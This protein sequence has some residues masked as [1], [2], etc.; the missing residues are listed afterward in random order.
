MARL[1]F[2]EDLFDNLSRVIQFLV[3]EQPGPAL[4]TADIVLDAIE[5]LAHHPLIGRP[6]QSGQRELVI[7]RGRSGY[8]A[9]Y[10]YVEPIDVVYVLSLHHQRESPDGDDERK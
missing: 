7:A 2:T 9:R 4:E 1:I 3:D 6:L 8:V 5:I 10:L